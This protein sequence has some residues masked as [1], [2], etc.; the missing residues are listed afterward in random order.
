MGNSR[1]AVMREAFQKRLGRKPGLLVLPQVMGH[2]ADG[3]ASF[4]QTEAPET[5]RRDG[6]PGDAIRGLGAARRPVDEI[7]MNVAVCHPEALKIAE[8]GDVAETI[9]LHGAD[10]PGCQSVE[11]WNQDRQGNVT[12]EIF[13]TRLPLAQLPLDFGLVAQ[14]REFR[15]RLAGRGVVA[16]I[17]AVL[18]HD[19]LGFASELTGKGQ[20]RGRGDDRDGEGKARAWAKQEQARQCRTGIL[21]I[22][23]PPPEP[24]LKSLI[25]PEIELPRRARQGGRRDADRLRPSIA[26]RP[27]EQRGA[28]SKNAGPQEGKVALLAHGW[29][30]PAL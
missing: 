11:G 2:D 21:G 18:E 24:G 7:D 9:G 30:M 23:V 4:D 13:Q 1:R 22:I 15:F 19:G 25:R 20:G 3:R 16:M 12:K 10:Q 8:Q 6:L 26:R 28:P 5:Q 29:V 27:G 14:R 17:P